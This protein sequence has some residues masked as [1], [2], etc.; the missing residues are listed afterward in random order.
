MEILLRLYL[1]CRRYSQITTLNTMQL[2]DPELF[3]K[4]LRFTPDQFKL[5]ERL[6]GPSINHECMSREVINPSARL[7]ICLRFLATGESQRSLALNYR[8]GDSTVNNILKETLKAIPN[9]MKRIV[10]PEPDSET[11][12]EIADSFW[13]R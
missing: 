2:N 9:V 13:K 10:L 5:L 8:I 6:I 1:C 3:F 4:Y 11:L 7:A 12:K